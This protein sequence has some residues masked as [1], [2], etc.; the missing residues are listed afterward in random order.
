MEI[1]R[2]LQTVQG[3]VSTLVF[4]DTGR[5]VVHKLSSLLSQSSVQELL[6][7]FVGSESAGICVLVANMQETSSKTINHIHVIIEEEELRTK[8][9]QCKVFVLLLHFPPAQ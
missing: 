3:A 7:D 4:R 1:L 2:D 9:G 6:R 8:A 5:L